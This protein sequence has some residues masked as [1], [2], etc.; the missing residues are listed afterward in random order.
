MMPV[1]YETSFIMRDQIL[2]LPREITFENLQEMCRKQLK[3]YLKCAA[4]SSMLRTR[5]EYE[6]A[7]LSPRLLFALWKR[8]LYYKLQHVA[9]RLSIQ[10]SPNIVPATKS[11]TPTSANAAPGTKNGTP[12]AT[13]SNT[14]LLLDCILIFFLFDLNCDFTKLLLD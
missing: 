4:D 3:C 9:L 13:K 10:I 12:P 2:R 14:E 5:S 8:N 11:D 6:L 7:A 1:T